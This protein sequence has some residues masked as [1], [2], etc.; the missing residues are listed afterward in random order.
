MITQNKINLIFVTIVIVLIVVLYFVWNS[1]P[2]NIEESEEL[3]AAKAKIEQLENESAE[4]DTL[5]ARYVFQADSVEK[6]TEFKI[7]T[8]DED[9]R[10][11][12]S[13]IKSNILKLPND[14]K[15]ELFRR[16]LGI[17]E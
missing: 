7:K 1:R 12:Y 2:D 4:K 10:I 17:N 13:D 11:K 5:I 6:A 15:M 9:I 8:D 3:K 16:N 14:K